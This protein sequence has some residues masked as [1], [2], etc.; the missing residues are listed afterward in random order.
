MAGRIAY[1]GNIVTNG[2]VLDLDAAKRDSYPGSGTVWRDIAGGVI[3]GSLINGPTFNPNNFG[4]IV[5][6][7]VDDYV[8]SIGT[9]SSF[10]FIQNTGIFTI[11]A[12]V[13]LNDLSAARYFLGNNDGTTNGIGFYL[14]K[15]V[16][17]ANLWLAITYGVGGQF[18]LN[19]IR[20]NFFTVNDWIC[21]TCV[22][23]GIDCQFYKN[24]V[25]FDSPSNFGTFST[26]NST[27]NLSVGRINNFNSSYWQGNVAQ[28]QIYN[29]AL[30]A[31][32]VLQNYNATK[33]RYGL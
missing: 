29:R 9:V 24:G 6:D 15:T 21:V 23:N 12:W 1:Y 13:R 5:F 28:T 32:E 18:T 11:N 3:N 26:G 25:S 16:S 7:G 27:R 8:D 31:T 22:G 4:S 19:Y 2:L 17:S 20:S 14:G 30:S 33:G 10:S